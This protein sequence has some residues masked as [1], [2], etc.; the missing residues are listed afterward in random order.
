MA[1][2]VFASEAV[3]SLSDFHRVQVFP[4]NVFDQ[5]DFQKAFV[6]EILN[7]DRNFESVRPGELHANGARRRQVEAILF[8]SDD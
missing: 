6:C 5:R 4:L 7:D 3:Q 8:T 1:Q 2:A